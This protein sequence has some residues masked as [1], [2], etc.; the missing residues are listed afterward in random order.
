MQGQSTGREWHF[1]ISPSYQA[2]SLPESPFYKEEVFF[3]FVLFFFFFFLAYSRVSMNVKAV[4]VFNMT[5]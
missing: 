4:V 1:R 2:R 5:C 3:C